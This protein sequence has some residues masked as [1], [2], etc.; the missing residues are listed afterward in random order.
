MVEQSCSLLLGDELT[1][2]LDPDVTC[3]GCLGIEAR[4]ATRMSGTGEAKNW[5]CQLRICAVVDYI[6]RKCLVPCVSGSNSVTTGVSGS[7]NSAV[8]RVDRA[9]VLQHV[10]KEPL[11]LDACTAFQ[12]L[13]RHAFHLMEGEPPEIGMLLVELVS[14]CA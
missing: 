14:E 13:F 4:L 5:H 12:Q 11:L 6:L 8:S 9:L 2:A 3:P 7:V 10:S 1:A